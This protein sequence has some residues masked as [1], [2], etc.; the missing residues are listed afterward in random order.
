MTM[1][2]DKLVLSGI[3]LFFAL[4]AGLLWY[5]SEW[6]EPGSV[7]TV[8]RGEPGGTG[9]TVTVRPVPDG[10]DDADAA[11]RAGDTTS[12][13]TTSG[14]EPD[15]VVFDGPRP[16]VAIIIDD[17]GY[18]WEF[19]DAFLDFP[20]PLT[21][22]VIPHLGLSREQALQ[23]HSA[24]H[25]VILHMPMEPENVDID[26]GP[27]GIYTSMSADEIADALASALAAVPGV[28]GM[29][30]HMGSRATAD[31]DVMR[32][33]LRVLRE[34]G[35]F[36]LDSFTA[37]TTVGPVVARD[38]AVP[39]A[40]NQVFL[41][42]ED[43][44]EHIRGQIHRLLAVAE[45]Q[46]SA[47]GIGHVR[48]RTYRAL[49]DMLPE[50]HAA[51]VEFVVVSELLRDDFTVVEADPAD[52]TDV[53]EALDARDTAAAADATDRDTET[54]VAA[55]IDDTKATEAAAEHDAT[56]EDDAA[57]EADNTRKEE[58]ENTESGEA[59]AP[60][61]ESE[62]GAVPSDKAGAEDESESMPNSGF[63]AKSTFELRPTSAIPRSRPAMS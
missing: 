63:D 49:M 46:G 25:E 8:G 33:V 57:D 9:A 53:D 52:A 35:L 12:G 45:R 19:A 50:L 41:D 32:T 47:V 11:D 17:W 39:Y 54:A 3:V 61:R 62:P 34:R 51:G 24:G 16:R 14:E 20:E 18:D 56:D 22:A 4:I 38:M 6:A 31:T 55:T 37:A 28:V 40:V 30:N 60:E 44:E 59:P 10:V 29:N 5:M 2:W 23:A 42:H 36:F 26:L 58:A 13:D 48:P 43:D 27:G 7:S 1:R 15:A 21:V